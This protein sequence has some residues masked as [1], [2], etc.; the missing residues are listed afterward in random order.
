MFPKFNAHRAA[1]PTDANVGLDEP[2]RKNRR[3][4][5]VRTQRLELPQPAAGIDEGARLTSVS[6]EFRQ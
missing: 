5:K 1:V 4:P 3:C 6:L 2:A